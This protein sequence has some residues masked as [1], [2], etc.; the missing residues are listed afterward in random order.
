MVEVVTDFLFLSYKIIADG[1]CSHEIGRLLFL[2]RKEMTNL[3]TV[4]KAETFIC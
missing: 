3:D 2:G 1:N 4:L